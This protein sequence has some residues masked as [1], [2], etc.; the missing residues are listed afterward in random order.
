MAIRPTPARNIF[1]ISLLR[2]IELNVP[3]CVST[4]FN[5]SCWSSKCLQCISKL[6]DSLCFNTFSVPAI[7]CLIVLVSSSSSSCFDP[8]SNNLQYSVACSSFLVF[9]CFLLLILHH[10]HHHNHHQSLPV[11]PLPPASFTLFSVPVQATL[12]FPG[13]QFKDDPL[14]AEPDRSSN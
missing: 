2:R 11:S 7:L 13:L 3:L 9:L 5:L 14:L 4:C 10:H 1:I 6:A 12:P 8:P